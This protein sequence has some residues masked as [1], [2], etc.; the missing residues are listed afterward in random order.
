LYYGID[1]AEKEVGKDIPAETMNPADVEVQPQNAVPEIEPETAK[2]ESSV[3]D[4]PSNQTP[5]SQQ[6][7]PIE[8]V[9]VAGTAIQSQQ[10]PSE[11]EFRIQ[12]A[13]SR[14]PLTKEKVAKLCSKPYRIDMAEENGWYKYHIVAGNS[15]ENAKKILS[16]CGADKAFIVPYKNGQRI[17][18]S[19]ATQ[20]TIP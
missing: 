9:A 10:I 17:T 20:K 15:Y 13:A 7:P 19:E 14:T 3:A 11:V 4:V 12:L 6:Q 5:Q 1:L 2:A 8:Q 18:L 16:D